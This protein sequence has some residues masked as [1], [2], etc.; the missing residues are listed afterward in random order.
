MVAGDFTGDG[1]PDLA[2]AAPFEDPQEGPNGQTSGVVRVLRGG[3]KGI[4]TS[5]EVVLRGRRS[6]TAGDQA[7]GFQLAAGDLDQDGTDD[8]VVGSAQSYSAAAGYGGAITVCPGTASGP[9]GCSVVH[10]DK[11]LADLRA[12]AVGN[13]SG[14]AVPE[15][16]ASADGHTQDAGSVVVLQQ[17]GTRPSTVTDQK[18]VTASSAGVPGDDQEYF[19]SS[20]ALGDV[21]HDGYADLVVGAEGADDFRGRVVIV[22]G[23]PDGYQTSGNVVLDQDTKGIPGK[24]ERNDYLGSAVS[25]ADHDADGNLDLAV[26][27]AR[28]NYT[29]GSVT[30]LQGFAGG[31]TTK[32]ARAFGMKTL[33][34][35]H[36]DKAFFGSVLNP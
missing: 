9:T 16:V 19:G 15:I 10:E 25:L 33:G 28:E 23:A 29:A 31:F 8:L 5:G 14:S 13:V 21:D 17:S 1:Y 20:L 2:V 18:L 34:Y 6:A 12:L 26:G 22:H 24:G 30:T 35:A 27:A 7:F 4:G 36:P 11:R 32:G 3:S